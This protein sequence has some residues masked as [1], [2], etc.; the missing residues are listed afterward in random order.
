MDAISAPTEGAL[1]LTTEVVDLG[2]SDM[3]SCGKLRTYTVITLNI[4][5][6]R[7]N[8]NCPQRGWKGKHESWFPVARKLE[9]IHI[10]LTGRGEWRLCCSMHPV[11]EPKIYL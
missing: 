5:D 10:E 1:L 3:H 4:A 2:L 6:S 8:W 7:G 11:A 9:R